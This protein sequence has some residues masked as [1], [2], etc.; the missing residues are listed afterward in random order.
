MYAYV[1]YLTTSICLT[2]VTKDPHSF[3][4]LSQA[5]MRVEAAMKHKN[6]IAKLGQCLSSHP[7][8]VASMAIPHLIHF[9]YY[10]VRRQQYIEP[11]PIIEISKTALFRRIQHLHSRVHA[12][13][14]HPIVFERSRRDCLL[15]KIVPGE[16]EVLLFFNAFA[17]KKQAALACN[18]VLTW[19]QNRHEDLFLLPTFW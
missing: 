11:I 2:L 9:V 3:H 4:H 5:R 7:F 8:T 17:N 19:I 1:H 6:F 13:P 18:R 15:A 14:D 12:N 16:L 10:N